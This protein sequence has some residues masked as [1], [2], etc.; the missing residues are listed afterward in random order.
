MV[1]KQQAMSE[2]KFHH[3]TLKNA[4]GTPIR[5]RASGSC[6]TWKTRPSEFMLPV[7]HG[8]HDSFYITHYNAHEWN[9]GHSY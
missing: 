5:C 2:R 3:V 9:V 7:K 8:L 4:D 6:K 1:T